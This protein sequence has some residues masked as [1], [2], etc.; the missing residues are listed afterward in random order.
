MMNISAHTYNA[1]DDNI[2]ILTTTSATGKM[3]SSQKDKH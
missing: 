1:V 3:W 2:H